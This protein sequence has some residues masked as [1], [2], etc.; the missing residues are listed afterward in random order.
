MRYSRAIKAPTL[1]AFLF[2]LT[3]PAWAACPLPSYLT[4]ARVTHVVD[5]DT[6][7]LSDGQRVRLI[8]INAPE[9]AHP[10]QSAQP[11]GETAKRR[12]GQLV[13]ASDGRVKLAI[14]NPSHDHYGRLLAHI[15]DDQGRS[16]EEIL[17]RE[18]LAYR[19]VVAPDPKLRSCLEDAEQQARSQ[20]LGLWAKARVLSLQQISEGGFALVQGRVQKAERNGGG[21]W[22]EMDGPLVLHVPRKAVSR[23]N[24]TLGAGWQQRLVGQPLEARGWIVDRAR[25]GKGRARW[26]LPINDP[27]MLT[28]SR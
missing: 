14:G 22:L 13:D 9:V 17:L 7:R 27:S 2:A 10:G 23:F 1:G 12:M 19:V 5:G 15:Y 26:M 25:H 21:V 8:G 24:Q 20:H 16:L 18:G 3:L 4:Q 28:P 6:L 11:Y